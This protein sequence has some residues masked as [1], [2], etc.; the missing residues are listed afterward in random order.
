MWK[1]PVFHLKKIQAFVVVRISLGGE[2]KQ[3]TIWL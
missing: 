1:V 3:Q 2:I